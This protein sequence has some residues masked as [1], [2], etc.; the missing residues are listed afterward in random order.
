MLVTVS[1]YATLGWYGI[2]IQNLAVLYSYQF[3]TEIS[4]ETIAMEVNET[5]TRDT[6]A[7]LGFSGGG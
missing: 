3:T 1:W 4:F 2:G 5:Y 7:D 6:V